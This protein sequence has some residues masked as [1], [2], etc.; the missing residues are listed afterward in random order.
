MEDHQGLAARVGNDL[1]LAPVDSVEA[2]A[3]GLGNRLFR[4]ET[5]CEFGEM[6]TTVGDF[7][8]GINPVQEAVAVPLKHPADSMDFDGVDPVCHPEGDGPTVL[9]GRLR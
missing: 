3:E 5:G 7:A 1:H 2:G 6:A 8:V 9:P 4:C